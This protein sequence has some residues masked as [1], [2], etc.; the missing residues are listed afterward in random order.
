[1]AHIEIF[2]ACDAASIRDG[3]LSILNTY[4]TVNADAPDVTHEFVVAMSVGFEVDDAGEHEIFIEM[5]DSDGKSLGESQTTTF[6]FPVPATIAPVCRS[7]WRFA[8]SFRRHGD[9][10][11]RL[12]CDGEQLGEVTIYF[13]RASRQ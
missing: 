11:F 6:S 9:Y 5:I 3:S 7:V 8:Y 4:N 1:M 10:G 12:S 13:R 2:T